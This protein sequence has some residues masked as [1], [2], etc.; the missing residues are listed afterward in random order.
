MKKKLYAGLNP[1][2]F[3]CGIVLQKKREVWECGQCGRI[4]VFDHTGQRF[5]LPSIKKKRKLS[6]QEEMLAISV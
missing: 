5:L 3:C 4:Y 2:D 6:Q 1:Q